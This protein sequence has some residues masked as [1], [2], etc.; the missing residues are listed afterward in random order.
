MC[1]LFMPFPCADFPS[2]NSLCY[3]D[4]KVTQTFIS[5]QCILSQ[6]TQL[7]YTS[8][9][10]LFYIIFTEEVIMENL[11]DPDWFPNINA[12][13]TKQTETAQ[14]Q[15]C[16]ILCKPQQKPGKQICRN[17]SAFNQHQ[18]QRYERLLQYKVENQIL[19]LQSTIM[20]L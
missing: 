16:C 5:L 15:R 9:Y 8:N 4:Y 14:N 12:P 3:D 19:R 13:K 10:G 6:L 2:M 20:W 11:T 18:W 17:V 7:R 1:M